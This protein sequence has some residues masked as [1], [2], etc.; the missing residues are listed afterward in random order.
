MPANLPPQFHEISQKV[1]EAEKVEEKIS[2]LE[3]LLAITPKHKGTEK[4][5]AEIK[6]KIAKLKKK[7]PKKSKSEISY[8]IPKEGAAQIVLVGPANSGKSS[9]LN[10]L[11]E[12]E[13]KTGA[14]PFTTQTLKPAMMPYQNIL[15]QLIDTP[16]LTKDSPG[17]MKNILKSS[18][19]II[20][21]FDLSKEGV[22][23]DI[24]EIKKIFK[25]WRLNSKKTI[26]V[27]NKIDLGKPEKKIEKIESELKDKIYLLSCEKKINIEK[28]KRMVFRTL[29]IIRVYTKSS[30]KSVDFEHPFIMKKNS[31]L[32]ELARKIHHDFK[33]SFKYAKLFTPG[34]KHPKIIGKDYIL[35]DE[36]IVEIR[37]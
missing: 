6:A 19:A 17:W 11:T 15:I 24:K 4:V 28:F 5:Q 16:P 10:V 27:A 8:F 37:I 22:I 3:E 34:S 33:S 36:D 23:E 21:V 25:D 9:L 12:A 26:F 1:K 13:T 2:L 29:E 20:A 30:N 18:D 32:V 35:Q 31:K 7:K 14:Y